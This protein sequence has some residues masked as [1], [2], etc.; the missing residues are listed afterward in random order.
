M[1]WVPYKFE[2]PSLV[3]SNIAFKHEKKTTVVN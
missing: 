1:D 3:R 2:L